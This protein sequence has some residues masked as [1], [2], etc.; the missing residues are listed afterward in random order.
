LAQPPHLPQELKSV[1]VLARFGMRMIVLAAFAA[2]GGAGFGMSMAA[3][4]WMSTML[5]AIVGAFRRE[6]PFAVVLNH[7]DEAA[8]Y[9]TLFSLTTALNHAV[10]A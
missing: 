5:S 8:A 2:F 6:P 4:L 9:A 3:L 10:A 1:Q 7:W